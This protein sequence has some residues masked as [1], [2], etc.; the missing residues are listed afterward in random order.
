[1]QKL[2]ISN[3]GIAE[4]WEYDNQIL[5]YLFE[6]NFCQFFVVFFHPPKN[7]DFLEIQRSV[8]WR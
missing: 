6:T 7:I 2:E 3:D 8:T 5:S 4:T 1:M